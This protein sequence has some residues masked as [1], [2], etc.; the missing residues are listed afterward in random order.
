MSNFSE[1]RLSASTPFAIKKT[2]VLSPFFIEK[3]ANLK[4]FHTVSGLL[5]VITIPKFILA[6]N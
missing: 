4:A 2:H 1:V 3:F 6:E 5:E